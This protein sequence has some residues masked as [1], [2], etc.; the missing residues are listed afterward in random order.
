[1]HIKIMVHYRFVLLL[2]L[3]FLFIGC[4]PSRPTG[5]AVIVNATRSTETAVPPT[6]VPRTP[7]TLVAQPTIATP[8]VTPMPTATASATP[9][10]SPT[11]TAVLPDA[12]ELEMLTTTTTSPDGRW[13]AIAAQSESIVVGDLEK[14]YVSLTVTDGTT[15]WTPVAEWRGYGLGYIWPAVYQWSAD[16]RYLY[17]TNLSSPDGC[18]Y[19]SNGTDLHRLDVTDG[20]TIKI[21]P[22]G[23]TLNLSLS[24]DESTPAYRLQRQLRLVH[25]PGFGNG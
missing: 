16:G 2:T 3:L 22:D 25:C 8:I 17:Y 20:S 24:A 18:L 4:T 5:D 15:T 10:A 21:L 11:P 6:P 1:M 7:T 19:Y 9:A 12:A 23:K 14:L 13:Q